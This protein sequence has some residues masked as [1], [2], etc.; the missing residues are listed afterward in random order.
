MR[1]LALLIALCWATPALAADQYEIDKSHTTILF[2]IAHLGFSQMIGKFNEYDGHFRFDPAEP[3]ESSVDITIKPKGVHTSSEALDE[4]LQNEHFFN[5][6]Q[7]PDI[8]FVSTKITVTGERDGDITGNLTMLGVTRPLTLHVH[9]NKADYRPITN[10]FAAGFSATGMLKR[11]DFGMDYAIPMVGDEVKL[12]I[13]TEGVDL[14][15]KNAE[16]IKH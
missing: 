8:H 15:R 14:D 16:K 9:L 6:K 13:E 12:M 7:F 11:S 3:E 10:E 4:V 1:I 5:S 2:F